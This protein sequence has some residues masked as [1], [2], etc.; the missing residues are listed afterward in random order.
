MDTWNPHDSFS[1]SVEKLLVSSSG[2]ELLTSRPRAVT[3]TE[4]CA[5]HF[6]TRVKVLLMNFINE[7]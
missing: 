6:Q 2:I 7:N 3:Q 4:F 5:T 1:K